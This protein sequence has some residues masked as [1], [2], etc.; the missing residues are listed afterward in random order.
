MA[1]ELPVWSIKV[2]L[3]GLIR[4]LDIGL[5]LRVLDW[6]TIGALIIRILYYIYSKE[7]PKPYSN[8]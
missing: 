2:S 3:R 7:P 4:I 6:I 1:L 5:A 8:D